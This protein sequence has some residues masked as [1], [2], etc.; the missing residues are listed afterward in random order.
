MA[1][2]PLSMDGEKAAHLTFTNTSLLPFLPAS[3]PPPP[4]PPPTILL[5]V[6]NSR[7]FE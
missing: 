6:T 1:T 2:C 3:Y 5:C 4:P 7:L